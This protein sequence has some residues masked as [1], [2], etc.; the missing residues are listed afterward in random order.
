MSLSSF[1][2]NAVHTFVNWVEKEYATFM[3][4]APVIE[5]Y[6]EQGVQYAV[7]V[8]KIILS[9]VESGSKAE[10]VIT[11]AIQDLLTVSAVAYDAGAHPTLGGMF[12]AIVNNLQGLEAAAGFKSANALATIAKVVS[13]LSAIAQVLIQLAPAV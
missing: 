9:Q 2:T 6:I 12:Q 10:T 4:D 13:T 3:K 11:K 1:F 8:L 7:G 5:H